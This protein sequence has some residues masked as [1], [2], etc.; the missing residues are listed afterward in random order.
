M[1]GITGFV[2]FQNRGHL[3]EKIKKMTARLSHRGPDDS[4]ELLHEVKERSQILALGHRRLSILDL[5]QK[6]HQPYSKKNR[7]IVL[8]YNGE[9]YNYKEI[10]SLLIAKGVNFQSNCDTEVVYEAYCHFGESAFEM[11]NGMWAIALIDLDKDKLI[12]SR[13]RLGKKPLYFQKEDKELVFAS[14]IKSILSFHDRD[15]EIRF[16]KLYRYLAL[17]YRYTE[18]HQES[19]FQGINQVK[20][21]TNLVV[22]LKTME[23][24]ERVYWSLTRER[25]DDISDEEAVKKFQELFFDAVDLRLRSD[26]P[27][28]ALLSGG[29]DSTAI[30]CVAHKILNKPIQTF[31]GIM[32]EL[33]GIYDESEYIEE[34]VQATNAK[35]NY[36]RM[37]PRELFET[38]EEMVRAYDEPVCTVSWYSLHLI[39][40]AI[41]EQGMKVILSG[42]GGDEI[43]AGYRDHY[44]YYFHYLSQSGKQE[45]LDRQIQ[46]WREYQQSSNWPNELEYRK[47]FISNMAKDRQ[48][49]H[50]Q[51]PDYSRALVPSFLSKYQNYPVFEDF[52]HNELDRRLRQELM[53]EVTPTM[54]KSEDRNTMSRSIESRCPLLDHRLVDFCFSLPEHLKIRDGQGKWLLREAMKGILPEKVRLRKDKVGLIAPADKWFRTLN[55]TQM[56]ELIEDS[57]VMELGILDQRELKTIFQ[58]HLEEKKNHQ[59]FLWQL[60]NFHSW[61]QIYH[62]HFAQG[63]PGSL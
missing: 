13:D 41:H 9:L 4:G 11:M 38:V 14:E 29:L 24:S 15:L 8:S 33:K 21:G 27:V 58:E 34:V 48:L 17:S 61:F 25:L 26:V 51:F 30:V 55:R 44:H 10:R 62:S 40:Q 46:F 28:G 19:F 50:S 6:G 45:E 35:S 60:L 1:C 7:N 47:D 22:C 31:S 39:V 57:P 5:T 36:I 12:L 23:M 49:E 43:L 59:M 53:H 63:S 18:I 16:E 54:V 52:A 37:K 42:H 20:P 3:L 32:G 2:S 56:E